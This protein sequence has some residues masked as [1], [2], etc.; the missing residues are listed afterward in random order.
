MAFALTM[1]SEANASTTIKVDASTTPWKISEYLNGMHFV[2]AVEPDA[3]YKDERIAEWMRAAKV[4]II[5]WPGGTAVM[6]YHWDNLTGNAF[7]PDRWS[8]EYVEQNI[9]GENYMDLD[10][11]IAYCRRVDAEP[12]V[13]VNI[14]SGKSYRTE[15][16][17]RREARELIQ[18]CVDNGYDKTIL[19]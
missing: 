1:F 13:G 17:S 12:M 2:Y 6:T 5:R 18:Y 4:K 16:D 14:K 15:D 11:F 7:G 19:G 3:L 10:E 8:P 9:N